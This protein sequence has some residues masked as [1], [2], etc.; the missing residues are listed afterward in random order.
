[1]ILSVPVSLFFLLQGCYTQLA[2]SQN[3]VEHRYTAP[4]AAAPADTLVEEGIPPDPDTVIHEHYWS[5]GSYYDPW[6]R[7]DPFYDH[8]Y[9]FDLRFAWGDPFWHPWCYR[10]YDPY[11]SWWS[12]PYWADAYYPWYYSGYG[13]YG[14]GYPY[15][16]RYWATYTY[17][18]P[19]P[20]KKRDWDRRGGDLGDREIS[21][22]ANSA[23][24]QDTQP[25]AAAPGPMV[26][27]ES[28]AKGDVRSVKRAQD[29]PSGEVSKRGKSTKRTAPRSDIRG[30]P[31]RGQNSKV[32]I[33]RAVRRVYDHVVA[34]K[35]GARSG[36][37]R[38]RSPKSGGSGTSVRS[39]SKGS[40]GSVSQSRGHRSSSSHSGGHRS[41][42]G[43][44]KSSRSGGRSSGGKSKR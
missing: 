43:G 15:R 31:G 7:Y 34:T 41:S 42:S 3:F 24:S 29:R 14:Y 11:W 17:V 2:V 4:Q 23:G 39:S 28:G 36:T 21:R 19:V 40:S 32:K 27:V 37:V 8:G 38:G 10:S 33:S 30:V 18:D 16:S 35:S 12:G 25:V 22:P 5:G 44:G 13:G 9:H 26:R 20:K 1:M 6:Y